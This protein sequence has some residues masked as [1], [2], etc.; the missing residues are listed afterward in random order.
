MFCCFFV[1]RDNIAFFSD[2]NTLVDRAYLK[3]NSTGLQMV[4]PHIFSIRILMSS[5]PWALFELK[6]TMIFS[7]LSP[8]K[9]IVRNLLSVHI[10][11]LRE[12]YYISLLHFRT[13][14]RKER[15]EKFS[16]FFKICYKRFSWN[17]F[18]FGAFLSI[19]WSI[20]YPSVL[21]KTR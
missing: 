21:W 9:L 4:S 12:V 10:C 11:D 6:L 17:N 8:V 19:V 1:T 5:W 2:G 16:F 14:P 3:V 15:I 13:L 7:I 18:S 20:C